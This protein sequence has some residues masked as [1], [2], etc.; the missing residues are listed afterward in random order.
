M[1]IEGQILTI[2]SRNHFDK[3]LLLFAIE[4]LSSCQLKCFQLKLVCLYCSI[5]LTR[6]LHHLLIISVC[7]SNGEFVQGIHLE[8]SDEKLDKMKVG[9]AGRFTYCRKLTQ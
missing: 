1:R 8:N 7:I 6:K 9:K 5:N 2:S 3:R 4:P